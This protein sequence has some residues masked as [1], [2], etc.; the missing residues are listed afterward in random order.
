MGQLLTAQG[1]IENPSCLLALNES[2][3]FVCDRSQS[4][5]LWE[6]SPDG[7]FKQVARISFPLFRPNKLILME[8][9][10]LAFGIGTDMV[11]HRIDITD[12]LQPVVKKDPILLPA[13]PQA[14]QGSERRV[15]VALTDALLTLKW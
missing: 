4:I 9:Q 13:V 1:T 7:G 15:F 14:V 12:P 2:R 11:V 3:V 10:I 5:S 8:S 6:I